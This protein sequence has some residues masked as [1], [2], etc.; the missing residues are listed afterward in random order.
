[1]NLCYTNLK[2]CYEIFKSVIT[3]F[4][5]VVDFM[6][7]KQIEE[8]FEQKLKK[9]IL[10]QKCHDLRYFCSLRKWTNVKNLNSISIPVIHC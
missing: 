7:R 10:D 1:M 4:G 8:H 3:L 2:G 9:E 5:T 6:K